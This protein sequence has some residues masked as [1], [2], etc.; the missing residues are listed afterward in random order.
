MLTL[1]SIV[2][3]EHVN[4]DWD[5]AEHFA[6]LF[7]KYQI[8]KMESFNYVLSSFFQLINGHLISL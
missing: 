7:Q 3:I 1:I 4:A 2:N 8:I 6:P 5:D